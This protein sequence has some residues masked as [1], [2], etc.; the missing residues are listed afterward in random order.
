MTQNELN[1]RQGQVYTHDESHYQVG[2]EVSLKTFLT[3]ADLL[4]LEWVYADKIQEWQWR[5]EGESDAG[6]EFWMAKRHATLARIRAMIEE[7]PD[8][9]IGKEGR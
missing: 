8:E 2:K 9:L 5:D 1:H 4:E 3:Y 7:Y 6:F